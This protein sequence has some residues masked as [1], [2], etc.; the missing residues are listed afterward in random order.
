MGSKYEKIAENSKADQTN[1]LKEYKH[2]P[3]SLL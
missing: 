2:L 3:R 1:H